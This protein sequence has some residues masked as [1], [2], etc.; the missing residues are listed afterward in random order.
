MKIFYRTLA[1]LIVLTAALS[2]SVSALPAGPRVRAVG[3]AVQT[4]LDARNQA[5]VNRLRTL[6]DR[7]ITQRITVLNGA[8][9]RVN[10]AVKVSASERASI[11]ADLNSNISNLNSLK[12]TI[13]ADNNADTLKT[14]VRSIFTTYR[15]YVVVLPRDHGELVAG[16]VSAILAKLNSLSDKLGKW[17]EVAKSRGKDVSKIEPLYQDFKAQTADAQSQSAAALADFQA[18]QPAA[19]T[20]QAKSRLAD[21]K[22]AMEKARGDIKAVRQDLRQIVAAFKALNS[23]SAASTQTAN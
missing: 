17:I 20:S 1:I 7:L 21:G 3:S 2:W 19:D 13:D 12:G 10:G 11:A 5:A 8:I 15:V 4:N 18:M 14:E 22:A 6:G 23:G 9:S 16:R